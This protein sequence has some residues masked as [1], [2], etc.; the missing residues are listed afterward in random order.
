VNENHELG[1]GFFVRES[2]I[3]AVRKL[4]LISNRISDIILRGLWCDIFLLNIHGRTEDK[5][6]DANGRFYE[7]LE[8]VFDKF[9]K[10]R[11]KIMLGDFNAKVGTED[12]FKPTV[13]NES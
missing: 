11:M 2:I 10:C 9:P 12:I 8:H 13:G 4:Q 6:D 3:S 5:I 1:T 7:E